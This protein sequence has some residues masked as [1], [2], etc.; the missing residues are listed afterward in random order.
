M[1]KFNK[2]AVVFEIDAPY[3]SLSVKSKV[4]NIGSFPKSAASC[5]RV[6]EKT[7][8]VLNVVV[9]AVGTRRGGRGAAFAAALAY[10]EIV[11]CVKRP[12][13]RFWTTAVQEAMS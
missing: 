5:L 7:S 9:T 13:W 6:R 10:F 8:V 12:V 1:V 4:S 3:N 11:G 2:K